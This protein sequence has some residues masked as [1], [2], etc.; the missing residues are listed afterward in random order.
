M[1]VH[2]E[3]CEDLYIIVS[4]HCWKA[5]CK[6]IRVQR[7][8]LYHVMEADG[9]RTHELVCS[10]ARNEGWKII[11]CGEEGDHHICPECVAK[12]EEK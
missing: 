1:T 4:M 10:A 2:K 9:R 8:G 6:T 3:F 7:I 11:D 12:E 5:G